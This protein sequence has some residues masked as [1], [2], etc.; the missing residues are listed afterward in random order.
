MLGRTL[1]AML[2]VTMVGPLR[3]A[4]LLL[5]ANV[6]ILRE[7]LGTLDTYSVPSTLTSSPDG[8]RFAHVVVRSDQS[9]VMV[10]DNK[11]RVYERIVTGSLRFSPDSQRVGYG[12]INGDKNVVVV[13]EVEYPAFDASAV[14]M[15]VFS[16]DSKR[17]AYIAKRGGKYCVVIDGEVGPDFDLINPLGFGFSADGA[18][19]A[20]AAKTGDLAQI[21]LDGKPLS[22]FR[23]VA[24]P[25]FSPDGKH[26]AYLARSQATQSLILDDSEVDRGFVYIPESLGFDGNGGLHILKIEGADAIR[27]RID[28]A[29]KA[30]SEEVQR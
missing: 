6:R 22:K 27:V 12:A 2:A 18:H 16:P 13:D 28:F 30:S 10:N 9:F 5:D 26:F 24:K 15:P 21:V 11:C 4:D 17:F 7:T 23:D 19:L 29:P 1:G 8:K 14:G 25:T 3:G 20:Y